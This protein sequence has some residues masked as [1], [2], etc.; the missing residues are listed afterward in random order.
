MRKLVIRNKSIKCINNIYFMKKKNYIYFLNNINK[1]NCT[2]NLE[3]GH[4]K[5]KN[6][7]INLKLYK[8]S[9]DKVEMSC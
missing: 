5:T 9:V 7:K 8:N 3:R 1:T 4:K 6:N 2:R